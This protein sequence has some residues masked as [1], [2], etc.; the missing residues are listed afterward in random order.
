MEPRL[1]PYMQWEEGREEGEGTYWG[2]G[3]NPKTRNILP[4]PPRM[5]Y[6]LQLDSTS[7]HF[8]SFQK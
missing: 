2:Q 5:T 1:S 6:F 7:S 4:E 3:V 8:H